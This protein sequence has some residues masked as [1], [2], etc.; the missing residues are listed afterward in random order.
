[1]IPFRMRLSLRDLEIGKSFI[2][3]IRHGLS[4]VVSLVLGIVMSPYVGAPKH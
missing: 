3:P 4:V 1:M 2:R